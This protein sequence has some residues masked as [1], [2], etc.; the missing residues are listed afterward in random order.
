MRKRLLGAKHLNT[1]T[2]ME[3]LANIYSY[4]GK[5]N[6]AEQL[7]VQALYIRKKLLGA[8]HPH[9]LALEIQQDEGVIII[10]FMVTCA[11]SFL[12]DNY[13]FFLSCL[14]YM[15]SSYFYH[16]LTS[17]IVKTTE[18]RSCGVWEQT[19]DMGLWT[20]GMGHTNTGVKMQPQ[21]MCC[22]LIVGTGCLQFMECQMEQSFG[23][24]KSRSQ[25]R[26]GQDGQ[27]ETQRDK[28]DVEQRQQ[29]V[30]QLITNWGTNYETG[31]DYIRKGHG[32]VQ[33]HS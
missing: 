9:A 5:L 29:I 33:G 30:L 25:S 23:M 22:A 24:R 1:L 3:D 4:Q 2:S 21:L 8:E 10:K 11:F 13:P 31:Q 16:V 27:R 17:L 32:Y 12:M 18:K 19:W 6:Q 28:Q 20:V 26:Q 14:S 7:Q 15:P